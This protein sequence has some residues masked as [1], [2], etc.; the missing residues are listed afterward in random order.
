MYLIFCSQLIP[1]DVKTPTNLGNNKTT[2]SWRNSYRDS[3]NCS[4]ESVDGRSE[5]SERTSVHPEFSDSSLPRVNVHRTGD[6][7]T[8]VRKSSVASMS[9]NQKCAES[10]DNGTIPINKVPSTGDNR[11]L[12]F[13]STED[14]LNALERDHSMIDEVLSKFTSQISSGYE[15]DKENEYET[16][17]NVS[18]SQSLN[19]ELDQSDVDKDDKT[20]VENRRLSRDLTELDVISPI[21]ESLEANSSEISK[22]ENFLCSSFI[23]DNQGEE[24]ISTDKSP[25]LSKSSEDHISVVINAT[26]SR[27]ESDSKTELS[28]TTVYKSDALNSAINETDSNKKSE[29]SNIESVVHEDSEDV[30]VSSKQSEQCVEELAHVLSNLSLE[31][32]GNKEAEVIGA[33]KGENKSTNEKVKETPEASCDTNTQVPFDSSTDYLDEDARTR[34]SV[35]M[36]EMAETGG[37][38]DRTLK[39]LRIKLVQLKKDRYVQYCIILVIIVGVSPSKLSKNI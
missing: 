37:D 6:V 20:F 32:K 9:D 33:D 13:G 18:R 39:E 22:H 23:D 3:G 29:K 24:L 8:Q 26:D 16:I 5:L 17:E 21:K 4:A 25:V 28:T 30:N 12:D 10:S 27:F 7:Y 31:D 14:N 1:G 19:T 34:R 11:S 35:V 36:R 38:V 15:A 2:E